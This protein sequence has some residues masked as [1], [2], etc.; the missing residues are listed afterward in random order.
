MN[1]RLKPESDPPRPARLPLWV[2][3]RLAR[4]GQGDTE[5]KKRRLTL[6]WHEGGYPPSSLHTNTQMDCHIRFRCIGYYTLGLQFPVLSSGWARL[7]SSYFSPTAPPLA[8][9]S[10]LILSFS[11]TFTLCVIQTEDIPTAT[12]DANTSVLITSVKTI[13]RLSDKID[14]SN[15]IQIVKEEISK[16]NAWNTLV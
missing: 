4:L 2:F 5:R 10:Q 11:V 16:S 3:I 8:N 9:P 13:H 12:K 15:N 6:R 1:G 14:Q 7:G